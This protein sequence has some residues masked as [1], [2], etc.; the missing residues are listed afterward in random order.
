MIHPGTVAV[1]LTGALAVAQQPAATIDQPLQVP[2]LALDDLKTAWS[3]PAAWTS[4]DWAR[5]SLGAAALV[6]VSLALDRPVDRAVRRMDRGRYDP[7]ANR[8]DTLGG[9]GTVVIA[10]GAYV[11]GL[12]AD[13]PR[14]REFGADAALSMLVAQSV[15]IPV[16]LLAG[17]FRPEQEAGPYHF[18]PLGGSQSFPSGHATQ[19]F[20]LAAVIAEYAD[21]P[22]ASAAAYG[23]AT[24]V[25]LARLEQRAHFVS[26]VA[27][28]AVI[29]TLSAK[30]VMQHHRFL[31][32]GAG[33]GV[34]VAWAPVRTR[35]T[36]GLMVSLKF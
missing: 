20:T 28:G 34:K 32:S 9:A 25:G 33:G 26:D 19:A 27:A 13:Q 17:R 6:G 18:K 2:A 3:A 22:W 31:R 8:L 36:T 30:A 12:L 16:K 35:D 7:W 14:V 21:N 5:A 4:G 10:G 23:G 1:L 11:G 24:L 15:T 29:G